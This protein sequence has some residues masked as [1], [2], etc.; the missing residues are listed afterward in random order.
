MKESNFDF[1]LRILKTYTA[2]TLDVLKEYYYKNITEIR[3]LKQ[4]QQN[5]WIQLIEKVRNE[6]YNKNWK[7][8]GINYFDYRDDIK[9]M[10]HKIIKHLWKTE[11]IVIDI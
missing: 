5:C 3:T 4:L 2:I 8:E 9:R 10:I 1:N 7:K 11:E 6:Y